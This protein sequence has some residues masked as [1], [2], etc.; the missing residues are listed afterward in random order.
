M[1]DLFQLDTPSSKSHL[2][3]P[4]QLIVLLCALAFG[5]SSIAADTYNAASN[6]LTIPLVKVNSDNSIFKRTIYSGRS[7]N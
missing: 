3:K 6:T 7:V 4:I 1:V 5:T 2:M